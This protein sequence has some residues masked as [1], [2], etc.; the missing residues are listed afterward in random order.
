MR[1]PYLYPNS[2]V[3][4]NLADVQEE[5]IL[6]DMEADYT[7]YRLSEIVADANWSE[8]DFHS[9]CEMHYRIFQDLYEWAGKPRIINIEKSEVVL[10]ELSI[11]YSDC[12]D[13]ERDAK[14]VLFDM[15]AFDWRAADFDQAVDMFAACMARL[16]KVHPYREGNTRTIV[17]FCS[18]FIETQGIYIESEL[19]KDHA[20]YMRDALVAANAVFHDIGDLRKPEYL[21]QIVRDAL[22]RGKEM[23]E[24]IEEQFRTIEL[25]VSEEDVRKIVFWNRKEREEHA[26]QEIRQYLR[27]EIK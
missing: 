18:M 4:K 1:D 9:L 15:N 19:F 20:S 17:T 10:G 16:W 21:Q 6:K 3:L 14:Q 24:H 27:N 5:Q 8:Y 2:E 12:F 13:I 7:S 25:T 26:A 23:R 22:E 11:E